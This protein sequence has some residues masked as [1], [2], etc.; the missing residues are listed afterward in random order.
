MVEFTCNTR[1]LD[2]EDFEEARR[3]LVHDTP[4]VEPDYPGV[5]YLP[6]GRV[7]EA[8]SSPAEP[9]AAPAN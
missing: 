2:E 5:I 6:D 4:A 7:I 8:P 3:L 9:A 1:A